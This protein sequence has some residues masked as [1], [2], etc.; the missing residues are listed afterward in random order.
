MIRLLTLT[1]TLQ[2]SYL[3]LSLEIYDHC[4][5]SDQMYIHTR[6]VLTESM[7]CLYM[8]TCACVSRA[9]HIYNQCRLKQSPCIHSFLL[10]TGIYCL[11]LRMSSQSLMLPSSIFL[12]EPYLYNKRA[13]PQRIKQISIIRLFVDKVQSS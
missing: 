4:L 9:V 1:I 11:W 10:C 7:F 12:Q 3:K 6:S 8:I 5:S 2:C 13:I